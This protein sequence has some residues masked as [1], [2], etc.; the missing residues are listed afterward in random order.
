MPQDLQES[1]SLLGSMP[2]A[3]VAPAETS[4]ALLFCCLCHSFCRAR[5]LICADVLVLVLLLLLLLCYVRATGPAGVAEPAWQ[6][7]A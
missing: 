3:L 4:S 7:A 5:C 6:H 2:D 1:L